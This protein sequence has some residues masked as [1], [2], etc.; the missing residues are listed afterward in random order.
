[1]T[2]AEVPGG[3]CGDDMKEKKLT[4]SRK[5]EA[6]LRGDRRSPRQTGFSGRYAAALAAA[7]GAV[8]MMISPAAALDSARKAVNLWLFTVLPSMFPFFFCTDLLIGSGAHVRLG[9][10]FEKPARKL[11]GVPGVAGF[12][13]ISSVL[14]GYPAGARVLGELREQ[15][16]ISRRDV[17][18]IL[19]FCSTSGPLF[20]LGAVGA[21]ML[22]STA[23]GYVILCAHYLGSL[24]TGLFLIPGSALRRIFLPAERRDAGKGARPE[25][26]R[27]FDA[28]I[29]RSTE[30]S[31]G[32]RRA[33]S[34]PEMMTGA[35]LSSFQSLVVIGGYI[36]VFMIVTDAVGKL[37]GLLPAAGKAA[38]DILTG[39]FE[40]TVGCSR[41]ASS[42]AGIDLKII[43]CTFFVSFGGLSVAAQSMSALK[44]SGVRLSYYLRFKLLQGLI[45]AVCAGTMIKIYTRFSGQALSVFESAGLSPGETGGFDL[46]S[47]DATASFYSL[48][49]S[50]AASAA[51]VISF[52][53]V[54]VLLS[55]SE[56]KK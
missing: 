18:E 52:Y 11:F 4:E 6:V 32:R 23:A 24:L 37:A 8:L 55:G 56:K 9:S 22:H 54:A 43:L 15:G 12:V 39:C 3:K 30:A 21:G 36:V 27:V 47:A 17:R 26:R 46:F 53:L 7:S 31:G 42:D 41:A 1:M 34:L 49:F 5:R 38:G 50:S 20:L 28:E 19:T 29:L 51:M 13:Y 44:N 16:Q 45:S 10:L 35:I 25:Q 33:G 48:F 40:M 14:S 2:R